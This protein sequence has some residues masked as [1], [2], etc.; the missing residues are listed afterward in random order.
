MSEHNAA[1]ASPNP[2]VETARVAESATAVQEPPP[3]GNGSDTARN[4]GLLLDVRVP[5]T[6]HLGGAEMEI[7]DI[8]ALGHGSIITLDKLAG[9]PVDIFVRG[10]LLARGEVIVIDES[11][12][13]RITAICESEARVGT[14]A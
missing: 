5:I 2:A 7:R 1:P 3:P 13:V 4:L 9:E 12:G 10:R 14:L 8:L 11:F 6:V